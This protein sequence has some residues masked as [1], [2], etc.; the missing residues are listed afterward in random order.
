MGWIHK[1]PKNG[2]DHR[3]RFPDINSAG[4]GSSWR[5]GGWNGCDRVWY[6]RTGSNGRYWDRFPAPPSGFV[7]TR[8]K[9]NNE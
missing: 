8:L 3:C 7:K 1:F 2:S 4:V 9:E 5:C 6:I